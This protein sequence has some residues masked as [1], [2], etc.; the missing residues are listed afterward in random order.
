MKKNY[1]VF[2]STPKY[3]ELGSSKKKQSICLGYFKNNSN[4]YLKT[5]NQTFIHTSYTL[6]QNAPKYFKT[7]P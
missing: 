4:T 2:L 3:L 1:W 5:H 6:L 7:Q